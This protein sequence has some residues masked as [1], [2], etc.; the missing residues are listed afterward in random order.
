MNYTHI[1]L[2]PKNNEPKYL[3]DFRSIS[4]ANVISRVVSKVLDNRLKNV[5]PRVISDAQSAFVPPAHY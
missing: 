3:S 1:V 5:L 4:L 2:I